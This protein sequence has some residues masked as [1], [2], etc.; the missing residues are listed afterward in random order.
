MKSIRSAILW[1]IGGC[2]FFLLFLSLSAWLI[3]FRAKTIYPLVRVAARGLLFFMG[4]PVKVRGYDRFDPKGSYL[5]MGNHESLFDIFIL[6][7]A[8]PMYVVG[9]EAAHHF[10]MPIW[11]HLTK[12]WGNIPII[13]HDLNKAIK[14]LEKA[15]QALKSGNSI[16]VLPE[17]HRTL[18]GKIGPF[19]KGLFHLALAAKA[20]ILPFAVNGLYEFRSK[21]GWQLSP[22]TAQVLFGEPIPYHF[23]KDLD[24][25]RTRDLVRQK[26]IDLKISAAKI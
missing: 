5:V 1:A 10:S 7:T 21:I 18:N 12:K 8:V 13:R 6:P 15:A 25:A 11:G 22:R 20:D 3:F 26:I 24:I 14:T 4:L 17:G 9:I 19:K 16:V 23:Y 2:Y